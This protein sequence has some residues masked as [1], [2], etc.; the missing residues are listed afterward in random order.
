M[1]TTEYIQS[2]IIE[3]YVLGLASEAEQQELELL[4]IQYPEIVQAR[5]SFELALEAR[6]MKETLAPP[7]AVKETIFSALDIPDN[8]IYA[9]KEKTPD[10]SMN[11]PRINTWKWMAAACFLLMACSIA[12]VY[13]LAGK[14][15]QLQIAN[16][17]LT[18]QLDPSNHTDALLALKPIISKPSVVW[19]TML[20]P[21]NAAHCAAHIYWDTL[22][23]NTYLLMGNIPPPLTGKQFQLWA[24][25]GKL[26]VSLGT[27]NN[28]KEGQLIQMKDVSKATLFI[29]TVEPEGGSTAPTTKGTYAVSRQL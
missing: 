13:F 1:N 4:C 20:E 5:L 3:C 10:I 18:R 14:N 23:T 9:S 8:R 26:S 12:W 19:S 28:S 16:N 6:L 7:S 25:T 22:S 15:K 17:E 21:S 29:I 11:V 27:F 2:G 24:Q